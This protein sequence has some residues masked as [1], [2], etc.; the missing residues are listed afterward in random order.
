MTRAL[1][2]CLPLALPL[3]QL[4]PLQAPLPQPPQPLQAWHHPLAV[5]HQLL[6]LL[7]NACSFPP[8]CWAGAA[9]IPKPPFGD[10][11]NWTHWKT[12]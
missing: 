2:L 10:F 6:L 5:H 1:A 3:A 7:P 12:F 8:H 11:N 9:Q 4:V